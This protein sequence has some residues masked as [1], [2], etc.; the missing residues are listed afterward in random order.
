LN[1][2]KLGG[3]IPAIILPMTMD[4]K[5]DLETLKRYMDWILGFRPGGLAVNADTGEGPHLHR[6]EKNLVLRKVV[7]VVRG[8]IPII[9]G[10][11]A[12]FTEEA[13]EEAK[14]AKRAGADAVLVFP[15]PAFTSSPLPYEI[16][17]EYHRA[18]WEEVGI[19]I[20][21]FQLQPALG[22]VLYEAETLKHLAEIEGVIALK[23]ASFDPLR[24]SQVLRILRTLG[25]PISLLTGNDNFIFESFLL[26]CD[27][28]LLGLGN[29]GLG[30]QIEMFEALRKGDIQKALG[31]R[32]RIQILADAIFAPPV[33]DY[34]ARIKEAL[35]M[36]GVLRNAVVRP[37]LRPLGDSERRMIKEALIKA[38]VLMKPKER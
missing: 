17:F 12:R 32:E 4:A 37:P 26:G 38:G 36:M 21:L 23:E 13:I 29:V 1:P 27:G 35:V 6:E 33:V 19:P 31:L 5:P 20:V 34:R 11:S 28:G 7:E 18:I 2:L 14:D 10:L 3:I 24:Y 16:P 25:R 9:A 8:R 22:G 15:I 30:L